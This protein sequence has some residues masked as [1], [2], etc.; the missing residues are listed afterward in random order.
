MIQPLDIHTITDFRR[1]AELSA[2]IARDGRPH[3]LTEEGRPKLVVQ[4]AVA[5]QRLLEAVERMDVIAGVRSGLDSMKRG[6]GRPAVK[7][8]EDLRKRNRIPKPE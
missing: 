1:N 3:L 2:Q 5:Y 4:D 7:A 6:E 8:L